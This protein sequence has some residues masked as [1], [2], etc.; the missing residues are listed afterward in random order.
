MHVYII[1]ILILFSFFIARFVAV[2]YSKYIDSSK[3]YKI[4]EIVLIF[5]ISLILF[6]FI[7][8]IINTFSLSLLKKILLEE[9]N[10]FFEG[11]F[12]L[13]F[14]LKQFYKIKL[15]SNILFNK[16]KND[17]FIKYKDE[18]KNHFCFSDEDYNILTG[19]NK[20]LMNSFMQINIGKNNVKEKNTT[21]ILELNEF[22]I[23]ISFL[24]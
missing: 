2:F 12:Q 1:I 15:N 14:P 9:K 20:Q 13:F 11:L 21:E 24:L 7:N 10:N 6:F 18:I 5:L 23:F 8:D 17:F 3:E 4:L 16:F 19:N 22:N